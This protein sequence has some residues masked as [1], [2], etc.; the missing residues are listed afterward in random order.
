MAVSTSAL[1]S[2]LVNRGADMVR[3]WGI[4]KAEWMEGHFWAATYTLQ[5]KMRQAMPKG[6]VQFELDRS[7]I[8]TL[9]S[10]YSKCSN[11]DGLMSE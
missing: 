8:S 6:C 3:L 1:P 9:E 10:P 2:V 7:T 11:W 4:M 5:V